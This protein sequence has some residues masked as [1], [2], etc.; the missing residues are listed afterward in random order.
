VMMVIILARSNQNYP[1]V[2]L[3]SQGAFWSHGAQEF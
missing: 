2:A 3:T 1:S